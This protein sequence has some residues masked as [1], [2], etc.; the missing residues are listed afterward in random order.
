[1]S[2]WVCNKATSVFTS[3]P[4]FHSGLLENKNSSRLE[5]DAFCGIA[6]GG[7]ENCEWDCIPS[8]SKQGLYLNPEC[9]LD[10][11]NRDQITVQ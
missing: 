7:K 5:D 4:L 3:E 11:F 8:F 9:M 10:C 6:T 2:S 1:M